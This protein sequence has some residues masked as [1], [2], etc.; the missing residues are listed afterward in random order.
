MAAKKSRADLIEAIGCNAYIQFDAH[1]SNVGDVMIIDVGEEFIWW[2]GRGFGIEN[3]KLEWIQQ[4]DF[5]A[6]IVKNVRGPF[7]EKE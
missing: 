7:K 4:I 2:S 5:E 3:A 1:C 6:T